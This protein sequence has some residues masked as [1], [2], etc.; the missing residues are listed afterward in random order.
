MLSSHVEDLNSNALPPPK[1]MKKKTLAKQRPTDTLG[2]LGIPIPDM[3][4]L[5]APRGG[6]AAG[7]RRAQTPRARLAGRGHARIGI[8]RDWGRGTGARLVVCLVRGAMRG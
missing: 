5:V 3:T 4:S 6:V 1:I 2:Q 7:D 8:A